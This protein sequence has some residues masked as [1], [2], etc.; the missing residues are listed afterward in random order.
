MLLSCSLMTSHTGNKTTDG[1]LLSMLD[2]KK[3][4]LKRSARCSKGKP[5]VLVSEHTHE[6]SCKRTSVDFN[7]SFTKGGG[8]AKV[9]LR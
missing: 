8:G 7:P 2:V 1:I 5:Y 3:Q 9:F 4:N 6:F